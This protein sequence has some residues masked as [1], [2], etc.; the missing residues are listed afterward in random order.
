[1]CLKMID[2]LKLKDSTPISLS[3]LKRDRLRDKVEKFRRSNI[4]I[5]KD[6]IFSRI[7]S[8]CRIPTNQQ[9]LEMAVSAKFGPG[10]PWLVNRDFTMEY[11]LDEYKLMI[12]IAKSTIDGTLE[13]SGFGVSDEWKSA[14]RLP[15]LDLIVIGNHTHEGWG[16]I[17]IEFALDEKL[18]PFLPD[19][20]SFDDFI[21]NE[22]LDC[23]IDKESGQIGLSFS[24][25][26]MILISDLRNRINRQITF[27]GTSL[28]KSNEHC[29]FC[30]AILTTIERIN[31][32]RVL[33][34]SE[35]SFHGVREHERH[36]SSG[37][38]VPIKEHKRSNRFGIEARKLNL[39][40]VGHVVYVACDND[41]VLRYIGE[42]KYG[43]P[44]HVNSGTSHNFKINEHFFKNGPM[45]IKI[46]ADG[47]SKQECLAIEK[48]LIRKHA[49]VNLW[50]IK[51]NYFSENINSILA[52]GMQD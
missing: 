40:E 2:S 10:N 45:H 15:E 38:I 29:T 4:N 6:Y 47:L 41:G 21:F 14:N 19:K 42:G 1:M 7:I 48:L 30:T 22:S 24:F 25:E 8:N 50:N 35:K 44:D 20:F 11:M 34:E 17:Y 23:W 37:K 31:K 13:F 51:D 49:G 28:H 9:V 33:S 39:D 12:K 5:G 26:S 3:K 36:L 18:L 46:V 32:I 52:V 43:R 27:G 16:N